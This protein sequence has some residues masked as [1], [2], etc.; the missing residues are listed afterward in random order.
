MPPT[1]RAR[2]KKMLYKLAVA[3]LDIAAAMNACDL[4]LEH[5]PGIGEPLYAA[6]NQALV[7]AYARPFTSNKPLG[8]LPAKWRRFD[9]PRH[10]E[11]HDDLVATRH[12]AVAHSQAFA[13]RVLI[14]PKG[15]QY[16]P[17]GPRA[18]TTGIAVA[19]DLFA[20]DVI[21]EIKGLCEDLWSRL[22]QATEDLLDEVY[23]QD[24]YAPTP[25]ELRIDED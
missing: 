11:L 1:P 22:N 5:R 19:T 16:V 12:R 23:P 2:T 24:F 25:F 14:V 4:L 10:Q 15:A 21:K 17:G 7:I 13:G 18:A 9:N 6:L 8:A 3:R 20:D